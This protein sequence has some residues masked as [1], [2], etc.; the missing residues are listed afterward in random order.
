MA[1]NIN[2]GHAGSDKDQIY[3]FGAGQ[4]GNAYLVRGW[5]EPEEGF[6]WSEGKASI[7]AL[8]AFQGNNTLSISLWGYVPSGSTPQDVLLFI[9]GGFAGYNEIR[10]KTVLQITHANSYDTENLELTFYIPSAKSP[11]EAEGVNDKRRLGIALA[12]IQ[13]TG[14]EI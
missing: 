7:V 10:E 8:P 1:A 2:V 6:V 13:I 4:N 5:G 11:Q 14:D 12:V 3:W 9:N